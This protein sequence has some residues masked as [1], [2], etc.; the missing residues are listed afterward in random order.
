[1]PLTNAERQR[2]FR[3]RL[4]AKIN[5][6]VYETFLRQRREIISDCVKDGAMEDTRLAIYTAMLAEPD[7]S[8]EAT[9]RAFAME[10]DDLV[11][12]YVRREVKKR[13]MKKR[14]GRKIPRSETT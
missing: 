8:D 1:M 11:V 10:F 12:D 5:S 3:D 14:R 13:T 4:K 9:K 2:R 7:P 6:G